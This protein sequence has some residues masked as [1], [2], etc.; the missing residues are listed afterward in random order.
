MLQRKTP[1]R[2]QS[3]ARLT[4][5]QGFTPSSIVRRQTFL[6]RLQTEPPSP[7]SQ[8][9]LRSSPEVRLAD[10]NKAFFDKLKTSFGGVAAERSTGQETRSLP[11]RRDK[12]A[13]SS[14]VTPEL[15]NVDTLKGK[16]HSAA[17]PLLLFERVIRADIVI[18]NYITLAQNL[19]VTAASQLSDAQSS[20]EEQVSALTDADQAFVASLKSQYE[21]VCR[22]LSE[23]RTEIRFALPGS[24]SGASSQTHTEEVHIGKHVGAISKRLTTLERDLDQLWTE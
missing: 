18:E 9:A 2:Q 3:P 20:L 4:S 5:K 14:S 1:D 17:G 11:Q 10:P 19:Y 13:P 7:P 15:T 6:E 23:T 8:E 12:D 21:H 22:P 16:I 24:S